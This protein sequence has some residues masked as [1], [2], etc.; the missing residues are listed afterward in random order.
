MKIDDDLSLYARRTKLEA[1]QHADRAQQLRATDALANMHGAPEQQAQTY[2][3]RHRAALEHEETQAQ[4]KGE[5][6]AVAERGY[7]LARPREELAD[8]EF[9]RQN[10]ALVGAA[11][12]AG[13][14]TDRLD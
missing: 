13:L 12:N 9:M 14:V 1:A 4:R 7:M 10:Q 6:A 2:R 3:D 8:R 5:R 11:H